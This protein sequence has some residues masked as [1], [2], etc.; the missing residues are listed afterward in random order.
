MIGGYLGILLYEAPIEVHEA[1]QHLHVFRGCGC[2]P[3][4]TLNSHFSALQYRPYSRSVSKNCAH[5]ILVLRWIL[6]I[7]EEIIELADYQLVHIRPHA[8][9]H[10]SLERR[11]SQ[12]EWHD[13]I[14]ELT[15]SGP[16]S[17]I[18]VFALPNLSKIS[19]IS[20]SG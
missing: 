8:I 17:R 13:P 12:P 18:Y 14:F 1:H 4:F 16:E 15:I 10:I 9:V 19:E 5:V 6:R 7:N 20:G 2:R 11:I 3:I